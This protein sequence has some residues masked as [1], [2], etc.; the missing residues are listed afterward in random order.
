MLT[1][2]A[3]EIRVNNSNPDVRKTTFTGSTEVGRL[4]MKQ[5]PPRHEKSFPLSIGGNAPFIVFDDADL[6]AAVEG[7][8][9]SKFR[10][11]V[12]PACA[13][14]GFTSRPASM[15]PLRRNSSPR[16][17]NSKSATV[18]PEFFKVPG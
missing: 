8:S 15:M 3:K 12:R 11:P 1:G 5:V 7:A 14:T 16:S 9:I 13:R 6:D 18:D 17:G 4:L 10:M 2:D